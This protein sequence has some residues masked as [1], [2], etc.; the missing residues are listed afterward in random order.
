MFDKINQLK[1][2][3][4]EIKSRLDNIHVTGASPNE[5]V[6]VV[7]NGNKRL[8]D[9]QI[10]ESF[11]KVADLEELQDYIVMACNHALTQADNVNETEMRAAAGSMLPGFGF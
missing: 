9:V 1:K 8:I 11:H 3:M 6:K 7:M 10:S 2:Q 5:M 4:D